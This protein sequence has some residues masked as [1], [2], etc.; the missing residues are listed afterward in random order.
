MIRADKAGSASKWARQPSSVTLHLEEAS[1]R[2][3]RE[4]RHRR[5]RRFNADVVQEA[6]G[7]CETPRKRRLPGYGAAEESR[8]F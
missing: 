6:V 7:A 4:D 1:E 2:N 3:D 5:S 8:R